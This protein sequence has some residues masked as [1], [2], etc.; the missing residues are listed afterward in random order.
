[1]TPTSAQVARIEA[2]FAGWDKPDR[3]GA[4]V[5]VARGGETIFRRG[6]G[7][8]SIEQGTPIG[9]DTAFRV[10]SVTK[11]FCCLAALM[12]VRDGKLGLDDD[13]RRHWPALPRYGRTITIRHLMHNASGLRDY[14]TMMPLCGYWFDRM[15][16]HDEIDA[17]IGRQ[18]AINFQPGSRFLYSNSNFVLISRIVEKL[19]GKPLG[20]LLEERVFRPLGMT[21][22]RLATDPWTV[23]PGLAAAHL[24]LSDG[25]LVHPSIGTQMTGDAA[26]ISTVNDL[27]RW[28]DAFARGPAGLRRLMG[29]LATLEPFTNGTPNDYAFGLEAGVYRGLETFGHGGLLPGYRTEIMRV[30][31]VDLAVVVIANVD[32]IDPY[33]M[34]RRIMDIALEGD[35]RMAAVPAPPRLTPFVGRWIDEAGGVVM[36]ISAAQG[37]AKAELFGAQMLLQPLPDGR[38][39]VM[40]GAFALTLDF[41]GKGGDRRIEADVGAGETLTFRPLPPYR[42]RAPREIVGRYRSD[43]LDAD[44]VVDAGKG[45]LSVTVAGALSRRGPWVTAAIAPDLYEISIAPWPATLFARP[46]R[47]RRGRVTG[48]IVRAARVTAL[49]L[50]KI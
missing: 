31:A 34:A 2:L 25:R 14:M 28:A 1:M 24:R 41:R 26:L 33:V 27:L 44:W 4:A 11:Q 15:T 21:R 8:A 17:M 3:P 32:A 40:R 46:K 20:A 12:L 7:M 9:P 37:A 10:A 48:L 42:P 36:T 45:G 18:R 47:D 19:A 39:T 22:T 43:E 23:E 5:G 13:V 35:A 50:T 6:F 38:M 49:E 30:P 29:E 16:T